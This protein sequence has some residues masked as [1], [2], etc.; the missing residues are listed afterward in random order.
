MA[1]KNAF[2]KYKV[3]KYWGINIA[4]SKNKEKRKEEK[5]K[6]HGPNSKVDLEY[7]GERS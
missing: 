1:H 2:I 6:V 5:E 3:R 4:N 7:M